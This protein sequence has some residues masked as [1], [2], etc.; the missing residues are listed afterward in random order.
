LKY[1]R[2]NKASEKGMAKTHGQVQTISSI[3]HTHA[4][5]KGHQSHG[6]QVF[7]MPKDSEISDHSCVRTPE[8]K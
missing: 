7:R 5:E 6:H 8:R 4:G 2:E 3:E 1:E